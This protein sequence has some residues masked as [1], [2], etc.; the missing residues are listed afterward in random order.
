MANNRWERNGERIAKALEAVRKAEKAAME[1]TGHTAA[2]DV[3]A[4]PKV[5]EART[6]AADAIAPDRAAAVARR[7]EAAPV[8]E[9]PKPSRTETAA[10]RR[11]QRER[12]LETHRTNERIRA[13]Q[14]EQ[15]LARE[16]R[17]HQAELDREAHTRQQESADA[18]AQRQRQTADEQAARE[19]AERARLEAEI[20]RKRKLEDEAEAKLPQRTIQDK[21]SA[22]QPHNHRYKSEPEYQERLTALA[23][24]LRAEGKLVGKRTFTHDIKATKDGRDIR[25]IEHRMRE[26][27]VVTQGEFDRYV[28]HMKDQQNHHRA[29]AVAAEKGDIREIPKPQVDDA[30]G[31]RPPGAPVGVNGWGAALINRLPGFPKPDIL[32]PQL[33]YVPSNP[34]Q[35]IAAT[36]LAVSGM[37]GLGVRDDLKV[38]NVAQLNITGRVLDSLTGFAVANPKDDKG[39]EIGIGAYRDWRMTNHILNSPEHKKAFEV[40]VRDARADPGSNYLYQQAQKQPVTRTEIDGALAEAEKQKQLKEAEEALAKTQAQVE[41]ERA[42]ATANALK[43]GINTVRTMPMDRL[44]S[45]PASSPQ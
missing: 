43:S 28:A 39:L 26:G 12:E 29:Q 27:K 15:R 19:A 32:S 35:G 24:Q 10:E 44:L 21:L 11:A 17:E 18:A 33:R 7:A 13:A 25:S 34:T 38:E 22:I 45:G 8:P 5:A 4:L 1:A 37:V 30:A 6:A 23:E 41:K 16:A 20:G 3:K 42:S 36:F 40:A 2:K 14:E 9:A 31:H